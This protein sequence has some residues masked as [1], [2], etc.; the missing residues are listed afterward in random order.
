MIDPARYGGDHLLYLGDYLP[1]DHR[2][3]DLS[4]DALTDEFAPYLQRFNPVLRAQVDH[5]R[6]GAPGEIR[7]ARAASRLRADDS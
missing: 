4:V 7:A 1:A 3:F 2:Y 6:V 5:R